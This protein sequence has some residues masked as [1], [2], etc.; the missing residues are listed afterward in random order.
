MAV[1][2]LLH[3]SQEVCHIIAESRGGANHPDNYIILSGGYNSKTSDSL[4]CF[5]SFLAG[6]AQT[7]KAVE[8]SRF[9]GNM[10]DG[11]RGR[12]PV[13]KE[14]EKKH[15]WNDYECNVTAAVR[16][17]QLFEAGGDLFAAAKNKFFAKH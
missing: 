8:M 1:G 17:A 3:D 10:K 7:R 15:W 12:S 2:Y 11:R 9:L 6:E 13:L 14:Q 16:A 4:D 5:T